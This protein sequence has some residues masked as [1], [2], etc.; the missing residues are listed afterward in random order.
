MRE[1]GNLAAALF[2]ILRINSDKFVKI[3]GKASSTTYRF[4]FYWNMSLKNIFHRLIQYF[5]ALFFFPGISRRATS[6]SRVRVNSKYRFV[7]VIING[8][9]VYAKYVVVTSLSPNQYF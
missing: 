4:G 6:E 9:V 8:G 7:L 3:R 5:N 1:T 2:F